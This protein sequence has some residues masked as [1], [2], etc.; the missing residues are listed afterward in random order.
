MKFDFGDPACIHQSNPASVFIGA[1]VTFVL[2]Q[3]GNPNASK[4]PFFFHHFT[5]GRLALSCMW[6]IAMICAEAIR[7]NKGSEI[8]GA[9]ITLYLARCFANVALLFFHHYICKKSTWDKMR[10]GDLLSQLYA[11]FAWVSH[12][13]HISHCLNIAVNRRAVVHV[14][15]MLRTALL[16]TYVICSFSASCGLYFSEIY[17]PGDYLLHV[18][19]TFSGPALGSFGLSVYLLYVIPLHSCN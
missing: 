1:G 5:M 4:A 7:N 19:R 18:A 15:G 12:A 3:L 9:V 2:A 17:N 8:Q 14:E 6:W 10:S 11:Y 13:F 16:I